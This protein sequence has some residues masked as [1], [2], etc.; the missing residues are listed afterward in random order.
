MVIPKTLNNEEKWIVREKP[1][2]STISG[3]LKE[4]AFNNIPILKKQLKEPII[5]KH[6]S[7]C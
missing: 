5:W 7:L 1:T 2:I 4:T 3:L 6:S